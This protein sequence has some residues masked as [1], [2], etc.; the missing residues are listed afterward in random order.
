MNGGTLGGGGIVSGAV[1]VGRG[2]AGRV[3]RPGLW[4]EQATDSHWEGSLTLQVDATY[5]YTFKARRSESWQIL[6]VAN[7]VTIYGVTIALQG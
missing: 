2:V 6:V 7:G 5:T 4:D 3:S 1:T